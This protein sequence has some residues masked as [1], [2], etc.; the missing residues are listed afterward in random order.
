MKEIRE[1]RLLYSLREKEM[2]NKSILKYKLCVI[3]LNYGNEAD[4]AECVRSIYESTDVELPFILIVDN[5]ESGLH[6]NEFLNF[7]PS[8]KILKPGKNLGFGEG[9]NYGIK[10]AIENLELRFLLI[11]N[12]D[13]ILKKDT[14]RLMLSFA[15]TNSDYQII[16]PA[17]VTAENPPR[18]WYAGGKIRNDR[19]TPVVF[20]IEKYYADTHLSDS[21]TTFASGCAMMVSVHLFELFS[22]L[23][24]PAIFIYDE[25][26]ELSIRLNKENRK[27]GFASTAVVIHKCQGSRLAV[28]SK[29]V[30]QL[31]PDNPDLLF[32][33]SHTVRNRYYII[34]KHFSGI[35]ALLIS[36]NMTFYWF[37]KIFQYLFRLR[38]R[39]AA[40]IMRE[41]IRSG[42]NVKKPSD[43]AGQT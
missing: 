5:N 11:L 18:I 2:N 19:V 33:L 22:S 24:D 38:L 36:F 25:D 3:I 17:I 10:W 23:F 15:E 31:S 32:Y 40:L 35:E 41:M 43:F 13:T 29:P 16:T 39:A 21:V 37:M 34:K 42:N 7:Y 8:L 1:T 30:N 26:T 9:N 28:A 20:D 14:L 27:I 12:N 6:L 4:T